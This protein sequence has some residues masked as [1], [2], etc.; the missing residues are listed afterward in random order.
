MCLFFSNLKAHMIFYFFF[1]VQEFHQDFLKNQTIQHCSF[2]C[3]TS[4][5]S[6]CYLFLGLLIVFSGFILYALPLSSLISH[7]GLFALAQQ[8]SL[9]SPYSSLAWSLAL[10]F[11]I[12]PMGLLNFVSYIAHFQEFFFIIQ[13]IFLHS[14]L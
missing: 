10:F 4:L 2:D 3:V 7:A 14:S 8:I 6:F 11:L 5:H 13:L 1:R 12:F 9:T